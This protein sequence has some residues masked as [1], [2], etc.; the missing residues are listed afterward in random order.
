MDS[1]VKRIRL[2]IHLHTHYS[3][4]SNV[5]PA[6]L[7]AAAGRLGVDCVAITDHNDIDGALEAQAR[8]D[9]RVIVGEEIT[10]A[11]G[12]LIGLFLRRRISPGMTAEETCDQIRAQGGVVLAPHPFSTLAASS[13]KDAVWRLR[14]RL[15]AVE[16]FNAQNPLSWEDAQ[17]ATFARQSGLPGYVGMDAHLRWLPATYQ[18]MPDFDGPDGF[19]ESLRQ[20]EFSTARVGLR[21]S[22]TMLLRHYWDKV[23]SRP[24]PGFGVRTRL[25]R[26]C[27]GAESPAG[28]KS[29]VQPT[30]L[31]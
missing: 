24:R 19:R 17:A 18:S 4:D 27:G 15:D 7:L 12:H 8:G 31:S 29:I 14:D 23:F 1:I 6:T 28:A 11:D 13:L 22:A 21:Y 30:R 16:V 5:S 3:W 2:A 25:A 9:L 10:T 26:G 20:A